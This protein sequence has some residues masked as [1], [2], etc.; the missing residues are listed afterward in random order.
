MDDTQV[1]ETTIP[2]A[3]PGEVEVTIETPADGA[4]TSGE[5]PEAAPEQT[6][7]EVAVETP[8]ELANRKINDKI[9]KHKREA[10]RANLD[11]EYWK[12]KA[13]GQ[14]P[15]QPAAPAV[16][17]MPKI[18]DFETYDDFI[19]AKAEFAAEQKFAG[20]QKQQTANNQRQAH[21][22]K[23]QTLIQTGAAAH[24]D[25]GEFVTEQTPISEV[26]L[27]TAT[28]MENGSE[29]LYYLGKNGAEAQRITTLSPVQ[30]V[31]ELTK[32]SD[33]LASPQAPEPTK[34]PAPVT[35]VTTTGAVTLQYHPDMSD[36][37]Y[38]KWRMQHKQR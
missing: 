12:G 6:P 20:M 27:A 18:D 9:A 5:T 32:I 8:E 4:E 25:F 29:V 38:R 7:E 3:P 1:Q 13:E 23:V 36:A 22:T 16:P 35:P 14:Q 19:V 2:E 26:G 17:T 34:A 15:A 21:Q 33:K 31:M 11:A 28:E 37:D 30:Q 10:Q 24:E